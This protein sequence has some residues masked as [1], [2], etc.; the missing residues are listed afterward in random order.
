[1]TPTV[2]LHA[3]KCYCC[4]WLINKRGNSLSDRDRPD[5]AYLGQ[6]N[7]ST[8]TITEHEC[9]CVGDGMSQNRKESEQKE[10]E[11]KES[12]RNESERNES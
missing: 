12:E 10:S 3:G 6:I 4:I 8:K 1:M 11:R 5:Q 2:F 7:R 9:V